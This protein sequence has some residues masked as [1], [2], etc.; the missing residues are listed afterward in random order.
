MCAGC[1]ARPCWRAVPLALHC[2]EAIAT[3]EGDD[4]AISALTPEKLTVI[5]F[6]VELWGHDLDSYQGSRLFNQY[7]AEN[8]AVSLRELGAS[9]IQ[10]R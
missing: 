3:V 10:R 9:A 4:G 1:S 5:T 6:C 7:R 8:F 2:V